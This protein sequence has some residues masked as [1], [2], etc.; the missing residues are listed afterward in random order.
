MNMEFLVPLPHDKTFVWPSRSVIENSQHLHRRPPNLAIADELLSLHGK[1]WIPDPDTLLQIK[2]LV[3][4]HCGIGGHRGH[5]TTLSTIREKFIW[6]DMASDC[7][8]F[9]KHCLHCIIAKGGLKI[10][11]PLSTTLHASVPN[12]VIHFDYLYM[13]QGSENLKYTLVIRD[14]LSGYT[15][16]CPTTTADAATTATELARWIRVFTVMS[17]WISDQGSHFKNQIMQQLASPHNIFHSFT[18]AYSPWVNGTVESSMRHITAACRVL[19]S[20]LKLGPQY[21]PLVLPMVM[22][23]LNE[24]PLKRLGSRDGTYRTPLEFM[25]GLR[26]NRSQFFLD[27]LSMPSGESLTA[28]RMKQV[29]N[30]SDL[31]SVLDNLHKDVHQKVSKNRQRQIAFHNKKTNLVTPNFHVGD[32]VVVRRQHNKGH[33]IMFRWVG[34]RQITLVISDLVYEVTSLTENQYDIIHAARLLLYHSDVDNA[35]VT[36][37]LMRQAEHLEA[38]YEI[39][40]NLNDMDEGES[41]ILIQVQWM[42][43]LDLCDWTWQP[44]RELHQDVPERV[45]QF[46]RNCRKRKLVKRALEHLGITEFH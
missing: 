23:A 44:I 41:G 4:A 34:P 42:G 22:T 9:V 1:V 13:G 46:L 25:T 28:I 32:F 15:W 27:R 8:E 40:E 38:K 29:V 33:K 7:K 18:V 3:I 10:P 24:S 19:L 35:E 26:P 31:Q 17:I 2:I 37:D 14:D 12:E 36:P 30:I 45:E 43:L 20:E 39:I 21:W 16:L 6:T 11:R 5:E